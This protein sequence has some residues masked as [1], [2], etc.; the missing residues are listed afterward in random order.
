MVVDA[1]DKNNPG[2]GCWGILP[3]LFY[4]GFDGLTRDRVTGNIE[5][6]VVGLASL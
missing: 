3:L 2:T 5:L 4:L 6:S 1:M